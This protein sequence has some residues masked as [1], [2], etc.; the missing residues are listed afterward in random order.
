[1]S[2]EAPYA[3]QSQPRLVPVVEF[4]PSTYAQQAHAHGHGTERDDPEGWG[5]YWRDSLADAGVTGL[6]PFPANSW[7]IAV[8]SLTDEHVLKALVQ[9]HAEAHQDEEDPLPAQ[10]WVESL[11]AFDGGFVLCDGET[12]L[13]PP[14]C[15]CC[16]GSLADWREAGIDPAKGSLWIGHPEASLWREGDRVLIQQNSEGGRPLEP[17]HLALS[18]LDLEEAVK[19]AEGALEDFAARLAPVVGEW[20]SRVGLAPEGATALARKLAGAGATGAKGEG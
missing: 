6:D 16:L 2:A 18:A 10:E 5:R 15:C 9:A 19:A 3:F 1:M 13:V 14:G 4:E 11:G 17:T 12:A 8:E 20:L 7:L